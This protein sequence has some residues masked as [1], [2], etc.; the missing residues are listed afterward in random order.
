MDDINRKEKNIDLKNDKGSKSKCNTRRF[1]NYVYINNKKKIF[2]SALLMI[3]V[4][5]IDLYLPQLIKKIVDR[6]IVGKNIDTLIYLVL[7][8]SVIQ[9]LSIAVEFLLGYIYS[10]MRNSVAI[11]IRVAILKHISELSGRYYTD[12]KTGDILSVV[13]SDI[14]IIER[15][16]AELAFSIV[17][18]FA[19]AVVAL[20]FLI[21]IQVELF[22]F[23]AL[24]QIVLVLIQRKFTKS[25]HE[26]VSKIRKEYGEITNLIQEYVLNIMS[27]VISK[28]RR[29]FIKDYI[30]R[31][32]NLI[33][34]D[35][36]TDMLYKGNIT[37][38]M[39]INSVI[40]LAIYGYGGYKVI[41]DNLTL[42]SLLAFQSYSAMLLGPCI[43]IVNA[44]NRL[45]QAKV[46]IDR[47][48]N[49][50][51][52]GS[53]VENNNSGKILKKCDIESIIFKNVGFSYDEDSYLSSKYKVLQQK[54]VVGLKKG[55]NPINS[56]EKMSI[57]VRKNILNDLNLKFDKGMVTALVGSSGCGKSTIINLV[58]R[59]WDIDNGSILIND[60]DIK[61]LNLN[62]L[63]K[64]ISVVTQESMIFDMSISENICLG[65]KISEE[66]LEELCE[67]VGL[68]TFL[69]GLKDGI[70]TKIGE[71]GV[72]ISGGQKQRIAIARVILNDTDV[73]ILD[74]A[75]SAL[76]NISQKTIL[77]NLREYLTEK[78]VIVIAHRLSTV[79]DVDMIYV[80]DDGRVVEE[81]DHKYLMNLGSF[82]SS[83]YER[84]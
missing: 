44:N 15:I 62:S 56:C 35:I 23:V 47:V 60:I 50:L 38:A 73:I 13:Q 45:Q 70:D 22:V 12:K 31:E 8:Y 29:F 77:E 42:G 34:K 61:R 32:K 59:L 76:D 53:E 7:I 2:I 84:E 48:Y 24:L 20:Y 26:N 67:R 39:L 25:I 14:D 5:I 28:S 52:E 78:I 66:R 37:V 58:Y 79:K 65:K 63:R 11:K 71:R 33:Q 46:S 9:V 81:G 54:S 27:I 19:T 17:K 55:N 41:T 72:K 36:K 10:I 30:K 68:K 64:N 69:E 1:T 40:T 21:S 51:D 4:T 74:E 49:L 75:T 83:L 6:G 82:Y 57:E 3:L 80:I 16:D 43:S 18:N